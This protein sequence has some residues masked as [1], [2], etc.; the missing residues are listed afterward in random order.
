[1][2]ALQLIELATA[3]GLQIIPAGDRLKLR[4]P[5]PPPPE[6]VN[7]LRHHKADLLAH[8]HAHPASTQ[9]ND[10][11]HELPELARLTINHRRAWRAVGAML[12]RQLQ[13]LHASG[14]PFD[15]AGVGV[16]V[17]QWRDKVAT[18]LGLHTS[19]VRELQRDLQAAGLVTVKG[20]FI[21]QADG[22]AA[23]ASR[24]D[25]WGAPQGRL[26]WPPDSKGDYTG[27]AFV[28]WLDGWH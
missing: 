16:F 13:R 14:T 20:C 10:H 21:E 11:D 19:E 25:P 23:S 26:C 8:L 9:A 5:A 7:L 22:S 17:E 18:R 1:M 4:A 27:R 12:E 24:A 28:H 15:A 6:L 3:H 2:N